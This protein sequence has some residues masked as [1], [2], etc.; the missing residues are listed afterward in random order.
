MKSLRKKRVQEVD[1][2]SGEMKLENI[3][4]KVKEK[5]IIKNI[6]IDFGTNGMIFIVGKSGAGKSSLLNVISGI[7][8]EYGGKLVIGQSVVD[9]K[10]EDVYRQSYV[11]TI[12]QDFNLIS[13]LSVSENIKLG[14]KIAGM[15]EDDTL[16]ETIVNKLQIDALMERA[17]DALSG[18]ERQ[19]VAI[20]RALYR[21]N[22]IICADE[23]T[24]NLDVANSEKFFELLKE[25]SKGKL[26]IVVS[27]DIDAA[28][29]YADRIIE[30]SDGQ[31]VK[32]SKKEDDSENVNQETNILGK[33]KK[34]KWLGAYSKKSFPQRA[35]KQIGVMFAMILSMICLMVILGFVTSAND[36]VGKIDS[37]Y[38]ENDKYIVK[39]DNESMAGVKEVADMLKDEKVVKEVV[40]YSAFTFSMG[41]DDTLDIGM[42]VIENNSFFQDRYSDITGSLPGYKQVMISDNLA[43]VYFNTKDVC[44]KT[45]QLNSNTGYT[46]DFEI[47]AVKESSADDKYECYISKET[48]DMMI[49][50]VIQDGEEIKFSDDSEP[51]YFLRKDISDL[52]EKSL[53]LGRLPESENEIVINV[54]SI[55]SIM[56]NIDQTSAAMSTDDIKKNINKYE[57]LLSSDVSVGHDGY[58]PYKE[59]IK[60]V[61]IVDD[62]GKYEW[63]LSYAYYDSEYLLGDDCYNTAMVYL[64]SINENEVNKLKND[65]ESKG[66]SMTNTAKFRSN[67]IRNR[68][69]SISMIIGIIAV[70][71]V[72]IS[73]V[74]MHYFMKVSIVQRQYEI[75]VLR[76]MGAKKG[77]ISE[78]M[79]LEQGYIA[80]IV[81]FVAIGLVAVC[82][83]AGLFNKF[84]IDMVQMYSF[85]I[86]HVGV[87][88]VTAFIAILL[89][90][91]RDIIKASNMNIVDGMREKY[92]L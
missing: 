39:D 55:N 68:I 84:T 41:D 30:I 73:A 27:H 85:R 29:R 40:S 66:F 33:Y 50:D 45:I 36:M 58:V 31:V 21:E 61:G 72:L 11:G 26:C 87:V 83:R 56:E 57:F 44:G 15:D 7:D 2:W 80:F 25:I 92:K 52:D 17:V 5:Q 60:I 14:R 82:E 79:M 43:L 76:G 24:G 54:T 38:L 4:K 6:S 89:F 86:W 23:P 62:E 70:I 71:I 19:R 32:D 42:N 12:Y 64:A 51:V 65:V 69:L 37:T 91:V 90:S 8:S 1:K 74:V 88:T 18:G 67:S 28:N 59:G 9:S 13:N 77:H 10:N 16:F 49:K 35:K 20:A 3:E 48:N 53:I 34:K 81:V 78:M 63:E 75:S 22:S 46:Y 47:S